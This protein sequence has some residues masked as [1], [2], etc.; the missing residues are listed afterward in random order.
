[1]DLGQKSLLDAWFLFENMSHYLVIMNRVLCLALVLLTNV[2]V[3]AANQLTVYSYRH[4]ET[5][6][7]LF[8]QFTEKT[9]IQVDV[10]K[11]KAGALLERLKAEGPSG[12]ADVLI[13]SDAGR[14]HQARAAGVLQPLKSKLL[15]E[16]IPENLRDSDGYWY[17]FTQRA[18]VF[19]Y[20]PSRVDTSELSTYADL[21]DKRWR[22][23][24]VVRSSSNVY[25]QSLLASIIEREGVNAAR[26]W[27]RSVRKNMARPPQGSDRDQMRAVAAG[28]ADVAVV[29]TY[30]L[31]LLAHSDNP[32]D[33][34]VAE[35]LKIFFPNQAGRGTH[36][37]VSGAGVIAGSDNV[38]GAQA[39]LEFLASDEAQAV[40]PNATYEYPVVPDV[41]WSATQKSWGDFKAD[42]IGLTR[43]GEL[44]AEAIRC[45]NLAGWQ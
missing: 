44:N 23:R 19:V 25:N 26:Q 32:K 11:S 22:G 45:F 36:V 24:L 34:A 5:D 43:L 31:G 3:E 13:T 8:K 4:Y 28:L 21:A 37:N 30:Y 10:V 1:M 16:R 20:A 2:C 17:G 42:T 7:A 18:R 29:N 40:F 27:A 39:L 33:R 15:E 38:E 35:K 6:V 12:P 41:E 14:L 9:G